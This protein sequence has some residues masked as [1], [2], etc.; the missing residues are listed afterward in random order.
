M[1]FDYH[2]PRSRKARLTVKLGGFT[3]RLMRLFEI[4]GFILGILLLL[5]GEPAGWLALAIAIFFTMMLWWWKA[6]LHRLEPIK[7][8]GNIDDQLA[9]N[10][11][12][13]LKENPTSLEIAE[14][15]SDVSGGRFIAQRFGVGKTSLE[16]L[17]EIKQNTP[18]KIWQTAMQIQK[19]LKT[20]TVSGG[21]LALAIVK[22]YPNHDQLL[23]QYSLSFEDLEEGVLWHDHIFSLIDRH[24]QPVKTGGI[25]R[26]WSFG[27]TPILDRFG[28]T[29]GPGSVASMSSNLEQHHD[30]VDKMIDQFTA[31]GKQNIALIGPDG[32][33]KTTV[34]QAFAEKILDG[35]SKI[36]N[37]LKFHQ[38]VMLDAGALIAAAPG[39]GELEGLLNQIMVEAYAAKNIILCL[40]NAQLFFEEAIGSVDLS[41]LLL[42]VLEA[43]NLRM[44]LTMDEQRFLQISSRNPSVANSLNRLQVKPANFKETLAVMQDKII[45]FEHQYKVV[46]MYQALR[47]AYD[48]SKRYIFDLEMPGRAVKLLETAASYADKGVVTALSVER[49]IEDSMNVK[50]TTAT[51]SDERE[52]LL[53]LEQLLH[54]RVIGQD[55]AISAVANALRRARS[56]V[57]S[58]SRP[59]GTFLFLGPTGVGKTE[60]AKALAEVY[61]GGE[62]NLIRLDLNEYVNL[63]DVERLIADGADNPNSLTAQVMKKPFSVILLDEI[64]KAHPNVLTALLQL[65]DEGVMRDIKNREVYFRD[66]IIIATSNAGA[67]RIRELIDRG[68]EVG[69]FEPQLIDDL[70]SANQFR[71]E[72]LNRFD[73]VTVFAPLLDT[74]LAQIVDLM[75][76]SINKT[77][78]GQKITVV[79]DEA[80]KRR[81]I[82]VGHDPRLGARPMRRS[83]QKVVENTVAR[84]LL[85]GEAAVGSEIVITPDVVD[86]TLG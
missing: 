83:I 54:E 63:S 45:F 26:D 85:S 59:I 9:S 58:Q 8:G 74:E 4:S 25:A 11:L 1:K 17:A 46:Y 5:Q 40:D 22:N 49:A 57:G 24:G 35:D 69:K 50:V 79:V 29:I 14:I 62:E 41:N 76:S 65:L 61:F 12:G 34:V 10:I 33:G 82:E 18:A 55:Q 19:K 27:Y 3:R 71:P 72:F 53:N 70:I 44:I 21:V 80:A 43:G 86:Q 39:R 47:S 32:A 13:R 73:E 7:G 16:S 31:S 42:P 78:A 77:L 20:N 68:Y 64:E 36:S 38:V 37:R 84:K 56:G 2:S 75:I 67:D 66:A 28:R 48:L 30:L 60:L 52:K 81:L 15:V 51:V 23:A 6:E